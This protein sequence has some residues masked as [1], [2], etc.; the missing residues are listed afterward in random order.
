MQYTDSSYLTEKAE[1]FNGLYPSFQLTSLLYSV[2]NIHSAKFHFSDYFAI[3]EFNSEHFARVTKL[4][5][6]IS[7]YM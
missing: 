7:R 1:R 6:I 2:S 4:F 5:K 3:A